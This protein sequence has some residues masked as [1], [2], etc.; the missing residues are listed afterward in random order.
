MKMYLVAIVIAFIGL[1]IS[2]E[3][4]AAELCGLRSDRVFTVKSWKVEPAADD[5]LDYTIVV[6]S[7][8]DK[9]IKSVGGTI[10]F[11]VGK[12]S[13]A[14]TK[15]ILYQ[16]VAAHA[17][18]ELDLGGPDDDKSDKLLK[19]GKLKITA[20]ACVDSVEYSDGSSVIIN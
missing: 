15:I 19:P 9:A 7:N 1:L 6:K 13:I 18:A 5:E 3:I 17:E 16:P 10:E 2:S 12:K 4:K 11:F 14:S 20:L 8:D